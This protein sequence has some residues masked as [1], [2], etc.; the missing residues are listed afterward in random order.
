MI[1]LT[2]HINPSS[3][4]PIY[5]Q[6][7]DMIKDAVMSGQIKPGEQ[8]PS[9]REIAERMTINSLTVLKAYNKLEAIGIIS[10]KRGM[11]TF[12][13][14]QPALLSKKGRKSEIESR[15]KGQIDYFL[16]AGFSKEEIVE[17]LNKLRGD[18]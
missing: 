13:A 11:G 18:M 15:F 6:I 10:T 1:K 17:V 3:G 2:I 12:V 5:R 8:L 4:V 14:D 16:R 7:M 9:I